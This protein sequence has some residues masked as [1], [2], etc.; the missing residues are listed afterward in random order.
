MMTL[1]TMTLAQIS[2]VAQHGSDENTIFLIM[3][4]PIFFS[5]LAPCSLK[6]R[7]VLIEYS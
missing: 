5:S 4:I 1:R 7:L 2:E 3:V 6:S